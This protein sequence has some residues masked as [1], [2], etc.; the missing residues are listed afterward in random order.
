M[1]HRLGFMN[2]FRLRLGL[3]MALIPLTAG[4]I[5]VAHACPPSCG[6]CMHWDGPPDTGRCVLNSG[7]TC[8]Q[9]YPCSGSCLK[10]SNCQCIIDRTLCSGECDECNTSGNCYDDSSLCTEDCDICYHASCIDPCPARGEICDTAN[11]VCVECFD[12]TNCTEEPYIRCNDGEC[13]ECDT[14]GDCADNEYRKVCDTDVHQCVQCLTD[15]NCA[16]YPGTAICNPQHQCVACSG[17]GNCPSGQECVG[18]QCR[19]PCSGGGNCPSGQIC[20]GGC[21]PLWLK[22]NLVNR[23][24][25]VKYFLCVFA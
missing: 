12:D 1:R 17:N 8:S 20:S 24:N 3:F 9:S 21:V 14:D 2:D 15:I 13:T 25:R 7:A 19:V 4:L 11:D 16:P 10:C 5:P 18:G 23:V 22:Q 6:P